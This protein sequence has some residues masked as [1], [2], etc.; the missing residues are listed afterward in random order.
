MQNAIVW[1][2]CLMM[3]VLSAATVADVKE[4]ARG[5]RQMGYP[6][7]S[8][9]HR[10]VVIPSHAPLPEQ[11]RPISGLL[12]RGWIRASLL[13]HK[14]IE[15]VEGARYQCTCGGYHPKNGGRCRLC[16]RSLWWGDAVKTTRPGETQAYEPTIS[17]GMLGIR[18]VEK[19]RG[20]RSWLDGR[21]CI[22]KPVLRRGLLRNGNN[23]KTWQHSGLRAAAVWWALHNLGPAFAAEAALYRAMPADMQVWREVVFFDFVHADDPTCLREGCVDVALA[24][25]LT[26]LGYKV[27]SS[28]RCEVAD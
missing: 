23:E 14:A 19:V 12:S 5:L 13:R 22:L 9:N 11:D 27:R 26:A 6:V 17:G 1:N 10:V 28:P 21:Y 25:S 7:P 3:N 20:A 18:L 4:V 24:E 15:W 2:L 16:N 8:L